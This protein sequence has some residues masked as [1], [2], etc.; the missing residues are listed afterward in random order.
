MRKDYKID[1]SYGIVALIDALGVSSYSIT[2]SI[3]FLKNRNKVIELL[4]SLTNKM[5]QLETE[6]AE[7]KIYTFG[8]NVIFTWAIGQDRVMK[9]LAAVGEWLSLL[10][11]QGLSNNMLFRGAVSVGEYVTEK[12]TVIG[13]AVADVAAWYE[14]ADWFGICLTPTL[15]FHLISLIN[16][17]NKM[18][19]YLARWFVQYEVPYKEGRT[20]KQW[21]IAWPYRIWAN[22]DNDPAPIPML[23]IVL[24]DYPKPKGTETKYYNSLDFFTWYGEKISHQIEE[25]YPSDIE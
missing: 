20:K 16:D 10:I 25:K 9:A 13:P 23:A 18:K 4:K 6:V 19:N 11:I 21:C 17:D 24:W 5:G 8:D 12:N 22:S 3:E 15:E 7:P 2:S 14:N 1:V